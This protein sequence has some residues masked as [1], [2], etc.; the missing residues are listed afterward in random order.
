MRR[1]LTLRAV[2]ALS[3]AG[4]STL[5]LTGCFPGLDPR[6]FPTT[7]HTWHTAGAPTPDGAATGGLPDSA[8]A[9]AIAID[10]VQRFY[11]GQMRVADGRDDGTALR[12]IVSDEMLPFTEELIANLAG[13][14][15]ESRGEFL[16]HSPTGTLF[17]M[18]ADAASVTTSVCV[19]M[20]SVQAVFDDGRVEPLSPDRPVYAMRVSA[21]ITTS[22]ATMTNIEDDAERVC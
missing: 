10:L 1:P 5:A 17:T 8:Q 7:S 15:A 11:D 14:F 2:A 3:L 16:V 6:P 18:T 20:S 13:Q 12:E 21:A 9:E 22:G 4:A 19:D